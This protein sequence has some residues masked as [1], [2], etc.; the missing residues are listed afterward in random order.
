MPFF[1]IAVAIMY[2]G[3]ASI[4]RKIVLKYVTVTTM[5][6]TEEDQEQDS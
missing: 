2:L 3:T 6:D 1:D 5:N 4:G